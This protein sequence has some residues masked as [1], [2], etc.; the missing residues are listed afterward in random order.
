MDISIV[1]TMYCSS[2]YIQEVII[3]FT[4]SKLGSIILFMS[5]MA[6]LYLIIR[7]GV[8]RRDSC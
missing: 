3:G 5:S 4:L 8:F 6:A 2:P 1:A 7:K